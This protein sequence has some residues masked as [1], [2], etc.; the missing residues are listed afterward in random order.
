MKILR[1][2]IVVAILIGIV[3]CLEDKRDYNTTV[4]SQEQTE[5]QGQDDSQAETNGGDED[6][7]SLQADDNEN[8]G[9][10]VDETQPENEE[11]P[12][13]DNSSNQGTEQQES[14][15][16]NEQTRDTSESDFWLPLL[17]VILGASALV[18]CAY[19][20]YLSRKREDEQWHKIDKQGKDID[21]NWIKTQRAFKECAPDKDFKKI[22][23]I[24]R[25]LESKVNGLEHEIKRI[26]KSG[27]VGDDQSGPDGSI[28]ERTG[29][30]GI[31]HGNDDK[32]I[33]FNESWDYQTDKAYFKVEY[34]DELHCNFYPFDLE[35]LRS[36]D[37]VKKAIDFT[38]CS[39]QYAKKMKVNQKG[40]A[41]YEQENEYW[42]LIDKA[43][44]V[45]MN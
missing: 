26:R 38:G 43:E 29:Y 15:P 11:T 33:F 10:E 31:P 36:V 34:I 42:R 9:N 22:A 40:F 32:L 19:N 37:A 18:L 8:E 14:Q 24:V 17:G 6:S 1:F 30:F 16:S 13:T 45:L 35:K 23:D 21:S 3:A 41:I 20:F 2:I 39:M 44:I 27:R 12:A 28:P 4:Q 25:T 7:D 5:S